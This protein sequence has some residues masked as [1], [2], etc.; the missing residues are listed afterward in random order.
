M[1]SGMSAVMTAI[2]GAFA[3]GLI[4]ALFG[5]LK[6]ALARRPRAPGSWPAAMFSGLNVAVMLLVLLAGVICDR[7][8]VRAVLLPGCA[9][10]A[11]GLV[12]LAG[13]P[14][15][16]RAIPAMLLAALGG[17]FLLV[18]STVL[19]PDAFFGPAEAAGS[20]A[21][22]GVFLALGS[23]M[24]PALSF[25]L[26]RAMGPRRALVVLAFVCLLPAFPAALAD[27]AVPGGDVVRA[28]LPDLVI[29]EHL[30]LAALVFLLYAPLEAAVSVWTTTHLSNLHQGDTRGPWLLS[31]FW[32][33]FLLSRLGLAVA[34]H[35]DWLPPRW[36][37]WVLV[38]PAL[39]IAVLL[40]N[41]AGTENRFHSRSGLLLLGLLLG[42]IYPTLVGG[43]LRQHPHEAGTAFALLFAA[44]SLGSFV[45]APLFANRAGARSVQFALRVP[46]LLAL[47]LTAAALVLAL[48]AS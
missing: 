40:G 11:V 8:G 3:S 25:V 31:G 21:L 37:G 39:L 44:G 38:L 18:G 32:L 10:A 12:M 19:M 6:L 48:A 28:R 47:A 46:M 2:G 26:E 1:M 14:Q 33:T 29:R 43:A 16:G 36:D 41:L 17:A 7:A 35:A 27:S 30:W 34:Q 23:L 9:A 13:K 5:S 22:G 15:Q 20:V 4:L 45:G 42:P 24:A